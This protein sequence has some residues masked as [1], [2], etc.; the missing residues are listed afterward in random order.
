MGP[1]HMCLPTHACDPPLKLCSPSR[2]YIVSR[3][4]MWT[5][6]K[7]LDQTWSNPVHTMW[8]SNQLLYS[9]SFHTRSVISPFKGV[10]VSPYPFYSTKWKYASYNIP[11]SLRLKFGNITVLPSHMLLVLKQLH[12]EN[13][14]P[15]PYSPWPPHQQSPPLLKISYNKYV[16][17]CFLLSMQNGMVHILER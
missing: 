6:S 2:R 8:C 9:S 12:R 7:W 3:Q 5:W 4:C 14:I 1:I 13:K 17:Q 16:L 11:F 10:K 15:P